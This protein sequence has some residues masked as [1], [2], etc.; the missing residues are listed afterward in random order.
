MRHAVI[1]LAAFS[2]MSVFVCGQTADELVNK[3]RVSW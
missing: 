3:N 2:C 1:V